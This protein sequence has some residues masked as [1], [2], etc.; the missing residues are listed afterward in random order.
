M[1]AP[2]RSSYTGLYPQ[3]YQKG[4]VVVDGLDAGERA[5]EPHRRPLARV[6]VPLF[7]ARGV[8]E[9]EFFVDNLLG[10]IH[11]IIKMILVDRPCVMGI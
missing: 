10:R 7:R 5:F 11:G 3:T 6:G 9:R 1:H 2:L 4:E 8:R